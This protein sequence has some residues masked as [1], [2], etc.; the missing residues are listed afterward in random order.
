MNMG[1]VYVQFDDGKGNS[2][3][4]FLDAQRVVRYM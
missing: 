3:M 4:G 1:I 2:K